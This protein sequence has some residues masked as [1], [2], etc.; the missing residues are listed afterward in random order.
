MNAE[1]GLAVDADEQH[2]NWQDLIIEETDS[3][4]DWNESIVDEKHETKME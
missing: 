3:G 1:S 2:F 4:Q